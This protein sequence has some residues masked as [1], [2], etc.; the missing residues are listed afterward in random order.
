MDVFEKA[1]MIK[2]FKQGETL[3][4]VDYFNAQMKAKNVNYQDWGLF[5][6]SHPNDTDFIKEYLTL[7]KSIYKQL[8]QDINYLKNHLVKTHYL[9]AL[10]FIELVES[11]IFPTIVLRNGK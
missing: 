6:T 9:K 1:Y 5:L 7:H 11:A 4:A 2:L 8:K 10:L 3:I